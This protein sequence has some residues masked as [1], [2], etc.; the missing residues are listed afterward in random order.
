MRPAAH[1]APVRRGGR[2]P[3]QE[4][5]RQAERPRPRGL[6]K[7]LFAL[8]GLLYRRHDYQTA[9]KL[10][11]DAVTQFPKSPQAQRGRLELAECWRNLAAQL[12]DVLRNTHDENAR[13][14][15]GTQ[16]RA[17]LKRASEQYAQ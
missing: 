1:P 14:H 4:H 8:G 12:N 7:S 3:G 17:W 11:E 9:Q 16:Q 2:D 13:E 15:Y 5:P 10:L 6:E